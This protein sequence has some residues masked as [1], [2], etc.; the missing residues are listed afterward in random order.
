VS[1]I[2]ITSVPLMGS[3]RLVA[4]L[5]RNNPLTQ[6]LHLVVHLILPLVQLIKLGAKG[7]D[8]AP[9]I[10]DPSVYLVKAY[11]VNPRH[12]ASFFVIPP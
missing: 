3:L 11:L 1:G 12:I 9:Q 6:G 2:G 7:L 4:P 8:L 5:E 10:S